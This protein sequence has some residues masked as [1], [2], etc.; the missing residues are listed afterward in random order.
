M[1]LE[2]WGG[3]GLRLKFVRIAIL[4]Q[5][6]IFLRRIYHVQVV[7]IVIGITNVINVTVYVFWSV[8]MEKLVCHIRFWTAYLEKKKLEIRI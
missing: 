5:N 8:V 6:P 3:L 7:W 4:V 1:A 2:K